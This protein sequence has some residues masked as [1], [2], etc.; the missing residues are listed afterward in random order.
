MRRK[1]E[2]MKKT[3]L[4]LLLIA[5]SLLLFGCGEDVSIPEGMQLIDGGEDKG[6]YFF[7]PE[8]WTSGGNMGGIAYVYASRVDTTS[9]SFTE[10]DPKTF[11]KPDPTKSDKDFFLEDYFNSLKSEFPDTTEFGEKNGEK[12][13]LGSAET[14]AD[15]ARKYTYNYIYKDN[16]SESETSY[17]IAFMQILAVH[18]ESYYILTYASSLAEKSEGVT[19]YD[20][21]LEN[22]TSVIDNF[23]FLDEK[24]PAEEERKEYAKDSDGYLLVS[25]KDL[26]GFDL[27]VPESFNVDYSSAIVSVSAEDGS[28]VTVTKAVKTGTTIMNYWIARKKA[29]SNHV[30]SITDLKENPVE[31]KFSNAQ[32]SVVCEYTYV[33]NGTT[34]RVY[35]IFAVAGGLIQDGYVFTYTA[36]IDNYDLHIDEVLRMTEKIKF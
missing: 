22:L 14:K 32:N 15:E 9:L 35:Q 13:L 30:E 3:L 25:D 7:A 6:Y 2:K 26:C 5:S 1:D 4:L 19:T 24:K 17:R 28:N 34:F 23:V 11:V 18:N 16:Y 21:H 36:E 10:I 33:Y 27:Y 8:E 20:Y 29:L 12:C 31:I